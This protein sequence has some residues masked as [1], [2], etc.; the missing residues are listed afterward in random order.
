MLAMR[1]GLVQASARFT[2]VYALFV[3]VIHK[4]KIQL[5]QLR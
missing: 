2:G 1:D 5:L 4:E 3:E